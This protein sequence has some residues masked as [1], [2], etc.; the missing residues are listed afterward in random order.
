MSLN[1]LQIEIPYTSK[2]H[3][4]LL[5]ALMAR[6]KFSRDRMRD[7]HEAWDTA[8]EKND[9]YIKET[10]ADAERR[11]QRE[12]GY[13]QYTTIQVP[14]SYATHLTMH[15][16]LV[17]VFLGRSPVLQFS[18]RHGEPEM[19]TQ[20]VEALMDYQLQVG[21]V[22]LRLFTW[23]Y[24][25]PKYG[26]GIIGTHWDRELITYS[27]VEETV[28]E[29]MGQL[30]PD[31]MR[32]ERVVSS[33]V[34]YEGNRAFNVRP[35]DFF[36]D[37]RVPLLDFQDGEFCG[38]YTEVSWTYL[39]SEQV[40]GRYRNL[41]TLK[42]MGQSTPHAE[43]EREN[44]V[45]E[46]PNEDTSAVIGDI[47]Q[48]DTKLMTDMGYVSLIEMFVRLVPKDWGLGQSDRPE[49]WFFT[50][51]NNEVIIEARPSGLLHGKF[52]YAVLTYDFNAYNLI[53]KNL[54]ELVAPLNDTMDW[55]FNSHLFNVRA[56]LNNQFV[57]DPSRVYS[58]DLKSRAPGKLIRLKETAW[59]TD[60]RS[61]IQQLPVA[62]VTG[63]HLQDAE[64]IGQLI[65]RMT[66]VTDNVMGMINPGGRKTATEVR[67]S[68]SFS[69]N[70]MKTLAEFYSAGGFGDFAQMLVQQTQAL[71]SQERYY[72][73]TGDRA[74]DQSA[75]T[76]LVRPE[77]IQGFYDFVP[78][79]GTLPIDRFALAN[80]WREMLVSFS[81][82][83]GVM[84]G[85]NIP[86][87]FGW[88]AQLAG[89]KNIKQFRMQAVPDGMLQQQVQAGN[90]ARLRDTDFGRPSEPGQIPGMGTTG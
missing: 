53:G 22:L 31:Q 14:Y 34:G 23:L 69:V 10:D 42:K 30:F 38:R 16:Y 80:L 74:D 21:K 68:S 82:V 45:S 78:V 55:L 76:V 57:Y 52:P 37:P 5:Q 75:Q 39:Q 20:Q 65:Q 63:R 46:L 87:I 7:F 81:R 26:V 58:T 51:A 59:G 77:E 4:L 28:P 19:A 85:Y 3:R 33:Q 61:V 24:D 8:E 83:P 40:K 56:T 70:R 27:R 88:I 6:Y 72:R 25:P 29:F 36:P 62:D 67:T 17:G 48:V 32:R 9:V 60:V 15:T 71:I 43:H 84:E 44:E 79:D 73:V 12:D 47:P 2:R 86:A 35:H 64:V 11:R 49:L 66:G 18:G 41:E 13:P 50:V 89:M 54:Y 90:V 1:E